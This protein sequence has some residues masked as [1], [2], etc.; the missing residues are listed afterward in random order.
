MACYKTNPLRRENILTTY[1]RAF[2]FCLTFLVAC[3]IPGIFYAFSEADLAR[4][5]STKQCR[6]C[7][8]HSAD[9]SGA[10]LSGAQLS[11]ASLSN[12]SLS[13]ANLSRA[14]LSG[15]F[16]TNTNL[17]GTNLSDAYLA[18]ANLSN[19][20]LSGANLSGADLTNAIWTNGGKCEKGSNGE[21]RLSDLLGQSK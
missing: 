9:L 1:G 4:L 12:A 21:C 14:N 6:W 5:M 3:F 13:N 20:D 19:A 11:N 15:D 17:S 18:D 10:Q 16:L 8:L 7:N 2:L